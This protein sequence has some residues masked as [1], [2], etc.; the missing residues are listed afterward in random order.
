M[1]NMHRMNQA[2]LMK[3]GWGLIHKKEALWARV[4]RSKYSCGTDLI[5]RVQMKSDS[6][7]MCKGISKVW[8]EL[9]KHLS[10][11]IGDGKTVDFWEDVWIPE[12]GPLK[13]HATNEHVV[14]EGDN[15][16][17]N[18]TTPSGD[19]NWSLISNILQP[20]VCGLIA[21]IPPPNPIAGGD[22]V[23]HAHEERLQISLQYTEGSKMHEKGNK[24]QSSV[25]ELIGWI[26]PDKDV[27]KCNVDGLVYEGRAAACG[28]VIRNA[29]GDFIV[30]FSGNVLLEAD[31]KTALNL[32]EK[33]V[34]ISHPSSSLISS[35][36]EY[37]QRDWMI[38]CKHTY[39]EANHLADLLAHHGHS[40]NLGITTL[41]I[42]PPEAASIIEDYIRGAVFP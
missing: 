35:I 19:W 38:T 20:N 8:E 6:S 23:N 24:K 21:G 37:M 29:V 10:W 39:R 27:V 31:S 3:A 28:G 15:K 34:P 12:L 18:F 33:G 16:V 17:H 22:T 36:R 9:D 41:N 14:L 40:L 1:R 32:I 2:Y 11:K 5:P 13:N 26:P 4:L 7:N 30:G 42:L 25:T